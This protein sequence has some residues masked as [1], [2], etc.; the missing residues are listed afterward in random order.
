MS[1][2]WRFLKRLEVW[3]RPVEFAILIIAFIIAAI[4]FSQESQDRRNQRLVASW[5]L[6]TEVSPGASGKILAL[7]YLHK[8]GEHL[9]G[10]DLSRSRHGAPAYLPGLDVYDEKSDRGTDF[11]LANFAGAILRGADLSA[12]H[13]FG[14]CLYQVEFGEAKLVRTDF[15]QADLTNANLWDAD[16]E[17][18]VFASANLSGTRMER[19]KGLTQAQLDAAFFCDESGGSPHLPPGLVPPPMRSGDACVPIYTRV[20]GIRCDSFEPR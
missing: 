9:T 5:Q 11:R 14:S 1:R 8:A 2:S 10:I 19:S 6:L 12:S 17:G 20:M 4:T 15:R 18:A 7:E 16:L 13:L 3:L